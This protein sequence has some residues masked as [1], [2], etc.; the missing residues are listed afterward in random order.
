MGDKD[1]NFGVER[2]VSSLYS[3]G[4]VVRMSAV[5]YELSFWIS[6]NR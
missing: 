4:L 1:R 6:I 3:R 5:R 2:R